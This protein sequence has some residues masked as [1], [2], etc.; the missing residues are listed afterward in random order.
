VHIDAARREERE[1]AGVPVIRHI[2]L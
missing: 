2:F 1:S